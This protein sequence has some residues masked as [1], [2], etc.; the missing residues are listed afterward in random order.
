MSTAEDYR[1]NG[2][3]HLPGFLPREVADAFMYQWREDFREGGVDLNRIRQQSALL[4]RP[5]I[6]V[7]GQH[8]APMNALLWGMTPAISALV[9]RELL[10][11]YA[12]FRVYQRGDLCLV[13]SDRPSCEIS[14][15]LTLAYSDGQPW[16]LE[17][18]SEQLVEPKPVVNPDFGDEPYA[19]VPMAVGDAVLYQGVHRRHG[20]TTPNP[21]RW[22]A[23]LFL[24]WVDRNGPLADRR[25]DG[26]DLPP[27][28]E[29]T[30][31]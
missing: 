25:F 2:Y 6:E 23:H 1:S 26:H 14:L 5:A 13:H 12:Y 19:A 4:I 3:V 15:S 27:P 9:E 17:M 24:H 11:T 28:A 16:A 7:Y 31:N 18:G 8:Y 30:F 20:R 22:S 21:N 10:P 29:A